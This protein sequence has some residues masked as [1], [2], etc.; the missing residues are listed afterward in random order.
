MKSAAKNLPIKAIAQKE[1]AARMPP[2]GFDEPAP[3][4][5]AC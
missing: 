1:G 5:A 2:L 3:H 4:A